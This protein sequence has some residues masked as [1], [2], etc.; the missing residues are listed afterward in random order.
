MTQHE[1]LKKEEDKRRGGMIFLPRVVTRKDG[2][3]RVRAYQVLFNVD[4]P[5]SEIKVLMDVI[6]FEDGAPKIETILPEQL[7][8]YEEN[9]WKEWFKETLTDEERAERDREIAKAVAF[10]NLINEG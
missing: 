1:K 7:L 9:G 3:E 5:L 10:H 2:I 6:K 4:D 8:S